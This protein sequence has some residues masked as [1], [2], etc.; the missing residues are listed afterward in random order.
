MEIDNDSTTSSSESEC[1][2]VQSAKNSTNPK[3]KEPA[4]TTPAKTVNGGKDPATPSSNIRHRF[5]AR[6]S[7]AERAAITAKGVA[8]WVCLKEQHGSNRNTTMRRLYGWLSVHAGSGC[9]RIC[10]SAAS[11]YAVIGNGSYRFHAPGNAGLP[12]ICL[13][14]SVTT[15]PNRSATHTRDRKSVV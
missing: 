9:E 5:N 7:E 14:L 6:M 10:S 8:T 12:E 4:P 11:F 15:L 13:T 3:E 1:D 2:S